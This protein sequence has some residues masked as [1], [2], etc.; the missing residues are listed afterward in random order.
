LCVNLA[1]V[2]VDDVDR[3]E[4]A[5]DIFTADADFLQSLVIELLREARRQLGAGLD[6]DLAGLR[7]DEIVGGLETA[8]A[9]WIERHLPAVLVEA[10]SDRRVERAQDLFLRHA[11]RLMWLQRL[12]RRRTFGAELLGLAAV[13]RIEQRRHRQLAAA[14]D[15]DIDVVLGVEF[16]IEPGAAIGDDAGGE[17]ILARG[18]ALALVVIEEHAGRAMH[19]RDDD[20]LGTV[21]DEGAVLGHERHVAHV[22]VLLFDVADRARARLLIDIPNDEAQRHFQRRGERDAALLAFL[23][24][25]FR[26]F[27]LVADEFQPRTIRKIADRENG[28][29]N[30]LQTDAGT[31]VGRHAHLQE[32]I[33]RALLDFDEVRHRRNL[34]DA[35]KALAN[36]LPAGERFSHG[37]SSIE[38]RTAQCRAIGCTGEPNLKMTTAGRRGRAAP[39]LLGL[40]KPGKDDPKTVVC[41]ACQ[42]NASRGY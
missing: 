10:E 37:Y 2:L 41:L 11:L 18:M 23:D 34:G 24:V 22:D 39:R 7:I 16:E 26:R 12:R 15:A 32:M 28:F 3:Q 1:G 5:D 38:I 27:E 36:A 8:I 19:L 29:E 30:F 25:V 35:A 9:R 42:S 17:E 21:D 13:E 14:V 40:A 4:L 6:L 33:V 31:L 20:A